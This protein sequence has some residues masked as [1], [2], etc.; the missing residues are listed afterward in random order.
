MGFAFQTF[1]DGFRCRWREASAM[2]GEVF[3]YSGISDATAQTSAWEF[4]RDA[5]SF[6]GIFLGDFPLHGCCEVVPFE[7]RA[8]SEKWNKQR[9]GNF[10]RKHCDESDCLAPYRNAQYCCSCLSLAGSNLHE[11]QADIASDFV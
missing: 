1:S 2:Q 7:K 9:Q 4:R 3:F 11:R 10:I 6:G 8:C 5:Q